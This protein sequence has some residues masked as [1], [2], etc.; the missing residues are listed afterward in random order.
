MR[1]FL[2]CY[3]TITSSDVM[4]LKIQSPFR[5][6]TETLGTVSDEHGKRCH[7]NIMV[8]EKRYQGKWSSRMLSDFWTLKLDHPSYSCKRQ[9]KRSKMLS[10]S[11]F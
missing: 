10:E 6:L 7:Q 1:W 5:L 4:S 8:M 9:V 2:S 11:F 3:R